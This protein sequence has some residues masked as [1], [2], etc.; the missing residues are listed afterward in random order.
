MFFDNL[1]VAISESPV[2]ETTDYYPFGLTFNSYT[3]PGTIGQ[4]FKYNSKE[5][6]TDLDLG[7]Y[8]YQARWYDP[9]LGR[10]HV[11]DPAADLMRR[12]SPYNYAFD[13]PIKFIDVDGMIP[14]PVYHKYG[15][16]KRY[17]SSWFG[18][19]TCEGCSPNHKGLDINFGS[20]RNDYGAPVLSTHDGTVVEAED[21]LWGSGRLITVRS[22]DG[23]F[24]TKYFHLKALNVKVG[25]E[26]KEG[27]EIG[28]IGGSGNN[29]ELGYASHLHYGIQVFNEETK[30]YEWYDPT[31]GKGK[32]EKNIVDPQSWLADPIGDAFKMPWK[33]ETLG[34]GVTFIN[35]LTNLTDYK[36]K[37]IGENLLW[38]IAFFLAL[39]LMSKCSIPKE[40]DSSK[41]EETVKIVKEEMSV[42]SFDKFFLR[43]GSDSIFQF[44]RIQFPL[45]KEVFDLYD[46]K[47]AKEEVSS[48]QW[49]FVNFSKDVNAFK[50]EID[51]FKI[52]IEEK[53]PGLVQ[54]KRIGIDNG[55]LMEYLFKLKKGKWYLV[56]LSDMST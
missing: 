52:I 36:M 8:D 26:V 12:H 14:W 42:E 18:P 38:Y 30:E 33:L 45:S 6:V 5:L 10:W 25:D 2:L 24:Q 27:A 49:R 40:G 39:I 11:V 43:F 22:A 55:I 3:K 19:R 4:N 23:K 17:I 51:A 54:Y 15:K 20:G 9:A 48:G 44:S 34:I 37:K 47:V 41:K 29:E 56:R 1:D 7:W 46:D 35:G 16:F 32:D 21:K 28:N 53:E 50:K 13:N 31:E